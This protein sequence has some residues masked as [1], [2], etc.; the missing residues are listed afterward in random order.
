MGD[1]TEERGDASAPNRWGLAVD[2]DTLHPQGIVGQGLTPLGYGQDIDPIG[3]EGRINRERRMICALIEH[4]FTL[5][6][7]EFKPWVKGAI[8]PLNADVRDGLIPAGEGVKVNIANK[9]E[10]IGDRGVGAEDRR[11]KTSGGKGGKMQ[12]IRGGCGVRLGHE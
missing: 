2:T 3:A 12:Q 8:G 5:G 1:A 11:L 6:I 9:V 10:T 4:R 7:E